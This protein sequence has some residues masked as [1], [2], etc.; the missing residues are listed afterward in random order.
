MLGGTLEVNTASMFTGS[1]LSRFAGDAAVRAA[2]RLSTS[3][4]PRSIFGDFDSAH[5]YHGTMTAAH[6]THVERLNGHH[7]SLTDISGKASGA[8]TAFETTDTSIGE[9][10][11]AIGSDLGTLAA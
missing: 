9:M 8:S 11:A 7:C 3:A 5:A 2:N 4:L 10:I 6:R 1:D